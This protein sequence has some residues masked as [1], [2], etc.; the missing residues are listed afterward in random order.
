M[1]AIR[2]YALSE[3]TGV[4]DAYQASPGGTKFDSLGQV[5]FA[6][7][8]CLSNF[9]MGQCTCGCNL[10]PWGICCIF[11]P[12]VNSACT[13]NGCCACSF[14]VGTASQIYV[15]LGSMNG[16]GASLWRRIL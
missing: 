8:C 15:A 9:C 2:R 5:V 6:M 13:G 3:I 16:C 14:T 1:P 7:P 12:N 11:N 10:I 4:K